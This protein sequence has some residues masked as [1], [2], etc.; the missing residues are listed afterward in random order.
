MAG[1]L[2]EYNTCLQGIAKA[3]PV[4]VLNL[5]AAISIKVVF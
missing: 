1:R 4:A 2:G 5:L 3:V